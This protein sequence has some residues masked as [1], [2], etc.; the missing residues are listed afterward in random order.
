MFSPTDVALNQVLLLLAPGNW[1]GVQWCLQR[2]REKKGKIENWTVIRE[3]KVI[4]AGKR[5]GE[6]RGKMGELKSF[7]CS[8]SF[9]DRLCARIMLRWNWEIWKKQQNA[10]KC[11]ISALSHI[12]KTS[13]THNS[14]TN[15]TLHFVN[16]CIILRYKKEKKTR[17]IMPSKCVCLFLTAETMVGMLK[18]CYAKIPV[19]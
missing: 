14:N 1:F 10:A 19:I 5:R 15:N 8:I 6:K 2:E 11:W 3:K 12:P 4:V 13:H 18:A 9:Q 7:L 16:F 17:K